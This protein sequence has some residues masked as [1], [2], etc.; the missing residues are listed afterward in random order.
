MV[1]CATIMRFS[2]DLTSPHPDLKERSLICWDIVLV[3]MPAMLFGNMLG[4]MANIVTPEWLIMILFV[5]IVLNDFI[6]IYKR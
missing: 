4:L 1:F 6:N 3:C 2:M 5:I